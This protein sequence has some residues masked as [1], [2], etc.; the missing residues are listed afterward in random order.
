M[1]YR[2]QC[3][4]RSSLSGTSRVVCSSKS[5]VTFRILAIFIIT[6]N[7]LRRIISHI[8]TRGTKHWNSLESKKDLR[9]NQRNP[10]IPSKAMVSP[11][12]RQMG[13]NDYLKFGV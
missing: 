8:L 2:T 4:Q 5:L 6:P 13:L 9:R 10:L 11:P 12:R 3:N 7:T 1:S